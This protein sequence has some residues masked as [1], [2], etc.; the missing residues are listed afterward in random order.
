M[1]H[2]ATLKVFALMEEE[3]ALHKYYKLLLLMTVYS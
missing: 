1:R 2:K 3:K